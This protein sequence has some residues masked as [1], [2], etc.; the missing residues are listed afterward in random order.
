MVVLMNT[1]NEA[2]GHKLRVAMVDAGLTQA[3]L[4]EMVG[5]SLNT[6]SRQM[7][8]IS[9]VTVDQLARYAEALGASFVVAPATGLEPVT[10]RS[11]VPAGAAA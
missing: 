2:T 5:L 7:R 1:V 8:G 4:A 6:V 9:A 10:Y 3:Q 11:L